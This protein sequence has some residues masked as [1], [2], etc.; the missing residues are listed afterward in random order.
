MEIKT[1]AGRAVDNL[2]SFGVVL[3][4]KPGTGAVVRRSAERFALHGVALGVP[5]V[6]AAPGAAGSNA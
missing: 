2:R 6:S 4:I 5:R 1:T 3:P